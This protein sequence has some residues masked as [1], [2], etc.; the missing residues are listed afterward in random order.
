MRERNFFL[1][2]VARRVIYLQY[3]LFQLVYVLKFVI[4]YS[5][6]SK[7]VQHKNKD[8]EKCPL[9]QHLISVRNGFK[10]LMEIHKPILYS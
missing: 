9:F 1:N 3:I 10:I 8:I 5:F 7:Y 4:M 2:F 6:L